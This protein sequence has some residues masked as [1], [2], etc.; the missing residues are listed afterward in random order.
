MQCQ[1]VP[2]SYTERVPVRRVR[3]V[4]QPVTE[5]REVD[6]YEVVQVPTT[7]LVE[8]TQLR[9]KEIKV[10]AGVCLSQ[11]WLFLSAWF[12]ACRNRN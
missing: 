3:R 8:E 1:L 11:L 4:R 5:I 2:E 10:R 12:H 6:D 9:T 7:R